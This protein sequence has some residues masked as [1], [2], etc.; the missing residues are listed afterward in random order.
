MEELLQTQSVPYHNITST[1]E[2]LNYKQKELQACRW[3]PTHSQDGL[4]PPDASRRSE[5][6]RASKGNDCIW[7]SQLHTRSQR[8]Y[9]HSSLWTHRNA[10]CTPH[11]AGETDCTLLDMEEQHEHPVQTCLCQSRRCPPPPHHLLI[12]PMG[13]TGDKIAVE[14]NRQACL[15]GNWAAAKASSDA[16]A[17]SLH[18]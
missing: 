8:Q 9:Q 18:L 13:K 17:R 7:A 3:F 11:C 10:L 6:V 1:T 15:N 12:P 2:V 5:S 4:I 16:G 14:S